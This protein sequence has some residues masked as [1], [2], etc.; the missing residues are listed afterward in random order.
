[1]APVFVWSCVEPF[2]GIVCAC[3]PTFAPFFRRWWSSVRSGKSNSGQNNG[4]SASIKMESGSRFKSKRESKR[5][6]A[7]TTVNAD[8]DNFGPHGDEVQ[9]TN[10]ISGPGT[11]MHTKESDEEMGAD[12]MNGI[13]VRE[14]VDVTWSHPHHEQ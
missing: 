4:Y 3:L 12:A 7:V 5:D 2:T 6:W 14:D 13:T 10:E 11:S 9:L 1:M 8:Y